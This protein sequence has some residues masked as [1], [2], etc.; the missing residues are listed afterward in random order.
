MVLGLHEIASAL[1]APGKGILMVGIKVDKGVTPL[2][3]G[4]RG[5]RAGRTSGQ[6]SARQRGIVAAAG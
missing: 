2:P 3:F 1:V 6:L 5:R 4:Q